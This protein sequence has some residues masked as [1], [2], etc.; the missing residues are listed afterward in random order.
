MLGKRPGA[1]STASVRIP[2][3]ERALDL[4]PV[5]RLAVSRSHAPRSRERSD[6]PRS[7]TRR[8]GQQ[9][10]SVLAQVVPQVPPP[11][12]GYRMA[13]SVPLHRLAQLMGHDSLDTTRI[14]TQ[15]TAGDLQKEVEK[16]AWE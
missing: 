13:E 16:I 15:G 12:V 5:A 3:R 11:P 8:T 14:Y 1:R 2:P 4:S 9:L 10:P 7:T 6:A